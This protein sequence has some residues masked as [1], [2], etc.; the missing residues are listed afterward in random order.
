M[1]NKTLV[2]IVLVVGLLIATS[3]DNTVSAQD[4]KVKTEMAKTK[5]YACPHHPDQVSDKPGKCEVCGMDLFEVK[6]MGKEHTSKKMDA[7][8]EKMKMKGDS[9]KMK[10]DKMNKDAKDMKMDM[11]KDMKEMKMDSSKMMMKK[12]M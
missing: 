1:K 12:K 6:D 9:D 4:A 11:K 10:M 3:V 7:M 8:H 2:S 5:K